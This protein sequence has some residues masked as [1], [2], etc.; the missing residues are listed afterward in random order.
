[1]RRARLSLSRHRSPTSLCPLTILQQAPAPSSGLYAAKHAVLLRIHMSKQGVIYIAILDPDFC[2]HR[3]GDLREVSYELGGLLTPLPALGLMAREPARLHRPGRQTDAVG[4]AKPA[5]AGSTPHAFTSPVI[6][7]FQK[8][9]LRIEA[10][11]V[12]K[13]WSNAKLPL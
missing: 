4:A 5:R 8:C 13:C 6:G 11:R 3:A 1:M 2:L 7:P 10:E 12:T 9:R